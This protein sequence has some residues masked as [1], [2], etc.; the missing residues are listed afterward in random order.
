[1]PSISYLSILLFEIKVDYNFMIL[2]NSLKILIQIIFGD[3]ILSISSILLR[4]DIWLNF[5]RMSAT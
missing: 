4:I 1:M 3:H 5:I 2:N